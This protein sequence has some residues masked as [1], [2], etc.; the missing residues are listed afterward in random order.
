METSDMIQIEVPL[1]RIVILKG[2]KEC[3]VLKQADP[4][5]K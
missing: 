2:V 1:E 5:K 4:S 3:E